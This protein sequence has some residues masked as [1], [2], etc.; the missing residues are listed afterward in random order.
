MMAASITG[1]PAQ[2][3]PDL[4]VGKDK[5]TIARS[6]WLY[7]EELSAGQRGDAAGGPL[8]RNTGRSDCGALK[9]E[10]YCALDT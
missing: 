3:S 2:A 5:P 9:C 7:R 4:S 1:D 8:R 10:Y 6:R